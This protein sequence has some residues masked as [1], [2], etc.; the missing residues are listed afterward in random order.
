MA[1]SQAGWQP[2]SGV[3]KVQ[4]TI[5]SRIR[6]PRLFSEPL[7]RTLQRT[8]TFANACFTGHSRVSFCSSVRIPA[9]SPLPESR[10]KSLSLSLPSTCTSTQGSLAQ[11]IA[12]LNSLTQGS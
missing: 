1:A 9:P 4:P 3:A 8:S 2:I 10:F 11:Q 5:F 6:R 12:H 7:S